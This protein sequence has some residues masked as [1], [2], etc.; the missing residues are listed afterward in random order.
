M[1][2][3]PPVFSPLVGGLSVKEIRL[4]DRKAWEHAQEEKRELAEWERNNTARVREGLE[5]YSV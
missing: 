2:K 1:P 3:L 4:Q 5:P